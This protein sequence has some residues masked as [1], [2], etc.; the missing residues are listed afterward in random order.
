VLY[1]FELSLNKDIPPY[2]KAQARFPENYASTPFNVGA[3]YRC[4]SSGLNCNSAI[5]CDY[6]ENVRMLTVHNGV[7]T[8]TSNLF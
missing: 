4:D 2:G 8:I 5:D 7:D 6:D 1:T 3:C